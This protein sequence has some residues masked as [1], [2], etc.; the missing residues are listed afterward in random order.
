M[1]A[2]FL[3]SCNRFQAHSPESNPNSPL[4]VK[5]TVDFNWLCKNF[6]GLEIYDT[7]GRDVFAQI[8]WVWK[9]M[10][11][12]AEDGS[13]KISLGWKFVTQE[14]LIGFSKISWGWKFMTQEAEMFL[15]TFPWF[16]NL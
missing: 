7:K 8:S 2:A 14:A 16:R 6:L 4:P 10:T 13:P 3:R 5:T 15:H 1:P 12:E 11:Q 9:F